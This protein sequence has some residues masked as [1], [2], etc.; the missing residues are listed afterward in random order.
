MEF[1]HFLCFAIPSVSVSV[2]WLLFFDN[3][4]MAFV[5]TQYDSYSNNFID[6]CHDAHKELLGQIETAKADLSKKGLKFK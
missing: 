5:Y 4:R 3:N 2:L 1:I 6:D